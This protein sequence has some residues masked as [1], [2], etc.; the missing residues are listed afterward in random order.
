MAC[1]LSTLCIPATAS[2]SPSAHF[3]SGSTFPKSRS[4]SVAV[5]LI[6]NSKLLRS[7]VGLKSSVKRHPAN[8]PLVRAQSEDKALD[9]KRSSEDVDRTR[10]TD[11]SPFDLID[12]LSPMRTMR[13]MLGT[14]DRLFENAFPSSHSMREGQSGFRTPWDMMESDTEVKMRFDMP[15]LSKEDVK[16]SIEDDVLVIKGESKKE[17]KGN[18]DSWSTRSYSNYSTRLVLPDGCETDKIKAELKNGVLNITVPKTRVESKAVNI[19]VE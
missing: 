15:G 13:Q 10:R 6:S 11:I 16:V 12:P 7:K 4:D 2:S 17:E 18:N 9:V 8:L 5:G 1:A 19:N 3:K 14:M